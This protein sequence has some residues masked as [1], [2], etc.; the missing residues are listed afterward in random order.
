MSVAVPV[1]LT[2]SPEIPSV[3]TMVRLP[4]LKETTGFE[5]EGPST[6]I[7][8]VEE[9]TDPLSSVALNMIKVAPFSRDKVAERPVAPATTSPSTNH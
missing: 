4:P 3:S 1:K 2:D 9:V 7:I 6:V 8:C 5:L